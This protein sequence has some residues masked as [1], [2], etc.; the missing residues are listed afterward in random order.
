M[1]TDVDIGGQNIR[2][3]PQGPAGYDQLSRLAGAHTPDDQVRGSWLEVYARDQAIRYGAFRRNVK[4]RT[5]G[6]ARRTTRCQP[7]HEL[8]KL[9]AS[10]QRWSAH[11]NARMFY[12]C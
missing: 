9:F 4:L 5:D 7:V 12:P 10:I 8:A 2:Q 3:V 11:T 6:A 1:D